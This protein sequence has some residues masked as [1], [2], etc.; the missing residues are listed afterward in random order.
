MAESL[1]CA[2]CGE[3][4]DE[5]ASSI[6]SNCGERF[7]L[8][9]RNDVPGKDC[10]TVWINDNHLALE[11]ACQRCLDANSQPEP[12][13]APRPRILRPQVGRRR[14]RKKT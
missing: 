6:C 14:Y 1:T 8:N 7:H 4:T 11:F 3:A 9:P 2:V 12:A 5:R 10:G 13:L